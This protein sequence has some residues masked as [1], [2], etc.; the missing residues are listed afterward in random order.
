MT[1]ARNERRRMIKQFCYD[2]NKNER[3]TLGKK[4][5]KAKNVQVGSR[6]DVQRLKL[7][8]II[9]KQN[10]WMR[11]LEKNS[12]LTGCFQVEGVGFGG[13]QARPNW[14]GETERV[15]FHCI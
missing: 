8:C 2:E 11:D 1:K 12:R 4:E 9:N 15:T 14:V 5:R 10:E 7:C 3:E 6:D 13:P